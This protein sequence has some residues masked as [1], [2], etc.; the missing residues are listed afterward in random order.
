MNIKS[1]SAIAMKIYVINMKRSVYRKKA[2]EEMLQRLGLEYEITE[3]V[4]GRLLSEEEFLQH[5]S[6]PDEFTRSQTGCALSHINVYRKIIEQG[7][8][9][10]LVLED[11]VKI[12][13][14]DFKQ[15]LQTLK[16]KLNPNNITILTYFWCREGY[17]DLSKQDGGTVKTSNTY[18]VCTP[19]EI[20]GIGRAAAYI[21]SK[22]TCQKLINVNYPLYAQADSWVVFQSKGAFNTID[23]VYPMPITENEQFG[24]EI[25]YTKT[26]TQALIKSIVTFLVNNNVPIISTIIKRRRQ[27]YSS[28][29]KNI[30]LID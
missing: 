19:S 6:Q 29:F 16:P 3:A 12:T 24:S 14:Q 21:V 13:E 7:E 30:R 2:I 17:L 22:A 4:D 23:C 26:K 8:E 28:T 25:E 20:H 10:G 18:H 27:A 9:Y 15:F 1:P 11:D 5:T